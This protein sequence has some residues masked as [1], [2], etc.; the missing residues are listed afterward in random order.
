[1]Q[2]TRG[3]GGGNDDRDGGG[4]FIR[5]S[6]I[7]KGLTAAAETDGRGLGNMA[8]RAA[9]F[10]GELRVASTGEGTTMRLLLPLA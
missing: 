7:G 4:E 9:S 10:G 3:S 6:D 5:V 8:R 2:V 1:V